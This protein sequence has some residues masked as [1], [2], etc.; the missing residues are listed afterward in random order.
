MS[1]GVPNSKLKSQYVDSLT[2]HIFFSIPASPTCK[3]VLPDLPP[4]LDQAPAQHRLAT[5]ER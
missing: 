4:K 2:S 3:I 1:H 5:S